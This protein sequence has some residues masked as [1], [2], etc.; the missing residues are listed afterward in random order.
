MTLA[1][2]DFE[3]IHR[4]GKA[5]GNA[6]AMTCSPFVTDA[7]ASVESGDDTVLTVDSS[8]DASARIRSLSNIY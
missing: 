7:P 6:D 8:G 2:Y 3:V 1:P 5:H 4:P